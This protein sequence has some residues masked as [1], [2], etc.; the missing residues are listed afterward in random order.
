MADLVVQQMVMPLERRLGRLYYRAGGQGPR[1]RPRGRRGAVLAG[2]ALL[3]TESYFNAFFEDY[4]RRYTHLGRLDLRVRLS[5]AGT[6]RLYRRLPGGP[7]LLLREAHLAGKEQEVYLAVL[8]AGQN[9]LL[10]FD[11]RARSSRLVLHGADWLARDAVARPVRLAVGYCTFDREVMLLRNLASL[12]GDDSLD[13][14]LARVIVADQG[15]RKV[16]R[17][18]GYQ[19]VAREEGRRLLV[20]EQD[21]HGGAGG[22]TRC[23]LEALRT[24]ATHIL[25]SD[26]D[27]VIEPEAVRRAAAFLALAREDVAVSGHLLDRQRGTEVV[28]VGGS[29]QPDLLAVAPA[30]RRRVDRLGELAGLARA[31][32]NDC[33]GWW[34]FA[35]GLDQLERIG[36]PLPLFLRGDD[37][38]F[39][40]RL[41]R[42]G[43]PTVPLPGV[44]IWH[45]AL[46]RGRWDWQAYYDLRN[47]LAVAALHFEVP[48]RVVVGR[49]LHRLLNRLLARRFAEGWLLCQAVEGYLQGPAGLREAEGPAHR[50]LVRGWQ[51]LSGEPEVSPTRPHYRLARLALVACNLVVPRRSRKLFTRLLGR[52]L[53]LAL[54]LLAGHRRSVRA[55]REGAAALTTRPFWRERL[56]VRADLPVCPEVRPHIAGREPCHG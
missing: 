9:G 20:V 1:P 17:H 21:N 49:F 46:D 11:L 19:A 52:G 33:G 5:G 41:A 35:F 14:V 29:Y 36:L 34:F 31:R 27:S 53:W 15:S 8:A 4:W 42:A 38:E 24:S 45:E 2:G 26:D 23:L 48:R 39:G 22:F 50:R 12:L 25:L 55:W 13:D 10:S 40:C 37:V 44:A 30:V 51:A 16:R 7:R 32:H 47:M 3:K 54:R 56:G 43:V 28:D 6:L 18:P